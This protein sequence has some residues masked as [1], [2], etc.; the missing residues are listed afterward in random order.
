[1]IT[2]WGLLPS[3]GGILYHWENS[4]RLALEQQDQR[5]RERDHSEPPEEG[6][7][8]QD[9][10]IRLVVRS[11][12]KGIGMESGKEIARALWD[13]LMRVTRTRSVPT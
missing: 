3:L 5:Q 4:G 8:S 12:I 11:V 2:G 1:M 6:P 13:I 10:L 7:P 9:G